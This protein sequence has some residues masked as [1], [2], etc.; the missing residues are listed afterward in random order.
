MMPGQRIYK[1]LKEAKGEHVPVSHIAAI[2]KFQLEDV[3]DLCNRLVK[4]NKVRSK[5]QRNGNG[6]E[7]HYWVDTKK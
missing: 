3:I 5:Y 2:V 4:I 6:Y 7:M 1:L